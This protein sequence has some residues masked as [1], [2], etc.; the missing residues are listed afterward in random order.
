[1]KTGKYKGKGMLCREIRL[2]SGSLI[3]IINVE[4]TVC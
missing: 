3:T 4:M 1:M 2:F